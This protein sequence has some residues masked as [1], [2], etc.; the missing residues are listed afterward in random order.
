MAC[1]CLFTIFCLF[2]YCL[3]SAA[4]SLSQIWKFPVNPTLQLQCRQICPILEPAALWNTLLIKL[5]H[6][7]LDLRELELPLLS[8]V[9]VGFVSFK[10]DIIYQIRPWLVWVW[11]MISGIYNQQYLICGYCIQYGA[12]SD[13][14]DFHP[15]EI[16]LMQ[17]S[18]TRTVSLLDIST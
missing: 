15:S 10:D 6:S 18:T 13:Q 9:R 11:N 2:D 7:T 16:F 17:N 12:F 3:L 5:T 1:L 14:N 4:D 8:R